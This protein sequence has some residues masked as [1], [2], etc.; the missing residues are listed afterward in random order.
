MILFLLKKFIMQ[1]YPLLFETNLQIVALN[2]NL[3]K[4]SLE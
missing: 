2:C 4:E 3:L 1:L